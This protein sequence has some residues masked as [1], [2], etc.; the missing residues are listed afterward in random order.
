VNNSTL[1]S[2]CGNAPAVRISAHAADKKDMVLSSSPSSGP[3]VSHRDDE[4][5]ARRRRVI[6]DQILVNSEL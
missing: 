4:R 1:V 3:A 5:G 6:F 2:S